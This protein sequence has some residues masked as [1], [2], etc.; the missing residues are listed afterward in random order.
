MKIISYYDSFKEEIV[1]GLGF[2]DSLHLGHK[3]IIDAAKVSASSRGALTALFTFDEGG[4]FTFDERVKKAERLGVDVVVYARFD[5]NFKKITPD[6]FVS[7]LIKHFKIAEFICGFDYTYGSGA[8]GNAESLT[9]ASKM[10]GIPCSVVGEVTRS[11]KKISTSEIKALLKAGDVAMANELLGEPYS[12]SGVVVHGREVGRG[13][14]FPTANI[15]FP[16]GKATIAE[17]VYA[18]YAYID[19]VRYGGIT[20]YGSRPTYGLDG[21]LTETYFDGFSGDLYGRE[22]TVYFTDFLRPVV[23]FDG[24]SAL[25]DALKKDLEKIRNDKIRTERKQ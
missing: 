4:V 11:G 13:I 1:L 17:G 2:F 18:S 19:G 15:N 23:R 20:N 12:V 10:R 24:A 7:S 6:R 14:G 8:K 3:A 9:R 25:A 5:E 21:V 16:Q 22:L